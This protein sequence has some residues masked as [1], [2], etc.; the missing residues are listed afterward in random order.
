MPAAAI[1]HR[2]AR[3][4]AAFPKVDSKT[5]AMGRRGRSPYKRRPG[6]RLTR[7]PLICSADLFRRCFHWRAECHR[8]HPQRQD[9]APWQLSLDLRCLERRPWRHVGQ[10][11]RRAR[12]RAAAC[13]SVARLRLCARTVWF[14]RRALD[15]RKAP[16]AGLL[17]VRTPPPFLL[18]PLYHPLWTGITRLAG[19][20][21]SLAR[22]TQSSPAAFL[23]V[24]AIFATLAHVQ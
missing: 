7:S 12:R 22:C 5:A 2:P 23:T 15:R 11:S 24:T 21:R 10:R 9:R 20:R 3:G 8:R 19:L 4:L 16:S 18:I 1:P 14:C 17:L 13:H 6:F